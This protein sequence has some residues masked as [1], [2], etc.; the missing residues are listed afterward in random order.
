M[1][2]ARINQ[3]QSNSP[4]VE[5]FFK[6]AWYSIGGTETVPSPKNRL[7]AIEQRVACA[8]ERYIRRP[9]GDVEIVVCEPFFEKRFFTPTLRR[10]ETADHN[11]FLQN[12]SGIGGKHL[13]GQA[14]LRRNE[15]HGG[16]GL[17][18]ALQP[19]PLLHRQS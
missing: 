15:N 13:V 4:A 19:R 14:G 6:Q 10:S 7:A 18:R 1:I 3:L 5:R 16:L 9:L 11:F 8:F 2:K 17:D 12:H